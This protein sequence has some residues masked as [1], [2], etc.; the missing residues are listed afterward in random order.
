MI[1]DTHA[2]H[3]DVEIGSGDLLIHAG[4][5]TMFSRSARDIADFDEWLGELPFRHRVIV[6]GNHEFLLESDPRNLALIT[7]AIVLIN[8]SVVIEGLRI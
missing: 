6:P 5:F 2:C 7:N 3:R 1:A 4:D 8:E